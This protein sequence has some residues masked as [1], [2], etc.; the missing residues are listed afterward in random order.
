MFTALAGLLYLVALLLPIYLIY[1]FRPM[2]WPLHVLAL[3]AAAG[4]GLAP[5][6]DLLN[7]V[8]GTYLYGVTFTFLIVWG[9]GGLLGYRLRKSRRAS[10]AA[11]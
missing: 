6:T 2:I 5:G 10:A 1:R 9:F 7:T 3:A 11:G 8:A 4:I